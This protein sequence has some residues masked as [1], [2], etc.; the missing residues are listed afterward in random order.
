MLF[1]QFKQ[2]LV[3]TG[4]LLLWLLSQSQVAIADTAVSYSSVY[5]HGESSGGR[6]KDIVSLS[7]PKLAQGE[8]ASFIS[9]ELDI[10]KRRF[11]EASIIVSPDR[12]C[13]PGKGECKVSVS[14]K[15]APAGRLKYRVLGRW[16]VTD[17]GC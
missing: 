3:W 2:S 7:A 5:Q 10:Q 9:A 6:G 13:K 17:S 14:W 16:E 12:G 1:A 8:C 11:G 15:H 4:F